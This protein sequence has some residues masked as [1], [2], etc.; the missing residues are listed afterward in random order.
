MKQSPTYFT[1]PAGRRAHRDRA[2]SPASTGW[3]LF[4]EVV[5][6]LNLGFWFAMAAWAVLP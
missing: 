4:L 3:Q 6:C 1:L 5:I 2:S